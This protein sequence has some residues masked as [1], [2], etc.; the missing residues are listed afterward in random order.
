[1]ERG[2]GQGN[3]DRYMALAKPVLAFESGKDAGVY[4]IRYHLPTS[5]SALPRFSDERAGME[6]FPPVVG[7]IHLRNSLPASQNL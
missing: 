2:E 4:R 3:V 6:T 1:M 5:P 7:E